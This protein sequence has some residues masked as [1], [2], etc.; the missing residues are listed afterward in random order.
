[1]PEEAEAT[2]TPTPVDT[3]STATVST[4]ATETATPA[5]TEFDISNYIAPDG[6]F[7]EGHKEALVPE[8][9]RGNKLYDLFPDIQGIMKMAGHQSI[10][11]GKYRSGKGVLPL[12]DKS[13][14]T[15]R[16]NWRI[17]HGV[18]KDG[19]GYQYKP[20]DDIS[21]EDLSPQFLTEVF[22]GFNKANYTPT[23]V[24]VAMDLFA[25]HLRTIEKAVD[26]ELAKAVSDADDRLNTEWGDKREMRTNLAKEFIT[27]AAGNWDKGKYEE[28]FGK[29]IQIPNA[30]GTTTT[31]REGGI[32]DPEF[33]P[34]RPLLMDL[35]ANI[36]E[37]YGVE[38]SALVPEGVGVAAK[39][40]QQQ[41]EEADRLV[42]DNVKLKE[43]LDTRDRAKYE[44]LLKQ[45]DA[46]YKRLYPA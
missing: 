46:L 42:Y 20:P 11:L 27:R 10:E 35:F 34:L 6:K 18:P 7:K 32:N 21:S 3:G 40:L 43:S 17:A 30:D 31:A 39:S 9:L 12:T 28:L 36:Q 5:A 14:P 1:M 19:T 37:K 41:L 33:A 2:P 25:N 45:R 16:E 44:E 38:D 23:Q 15:E 24:N 8:E 13:S 4:T 22:D 26:D 29:E